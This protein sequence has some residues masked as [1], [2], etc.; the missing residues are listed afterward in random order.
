[1]RKIAAA[2]SGVSAGTI[3]LGG[4]LHPMR[5]KTD[6]ARSDQQQFVTLFTACMVSPVRAEQRHDSL[7]TASKLISMNYG[8]GSAPGAMLRTNLDRVAALRK[9]E[10]FAKLSEAVLAELASRAIPRQLRQGEVLFSEHDNASGL[11]VVVEGEI[12]SVR[13]NSKGREQVLSTERAGAV[14]AVVPIFSSSKYHT[15]AIADSNAQVICIPAEDVHKLCEQ[16]PELLWAIAKLFARKL[17]HYAELIETL[18]LRN[19]DQRVAQYLLNVCQEQGV[20]QNEACT[21]E[22]RMTQAEMASRIGSTREVVCRAIAHL[23]ASGLIRMQGARNITVVS[24]RALSKFAGVEHDLEEPRS[25]SEL[26]SDV[27]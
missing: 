4:A 6:I 20:V 5:A 24:A 10:L 22:I 2:F 9:S 17:R 21:V 3:A 8:F 18:A 27:A 1:L 11:Y 15:T 19:V 12:R 26:S 23:E 13:Q 16:Y 25:L 7:I 14:L